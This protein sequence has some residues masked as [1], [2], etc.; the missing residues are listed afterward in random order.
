MWPKGFDFLPVFASARP[1]FVKQAGG[2]ITLHR[3]HFMRVNR[4][5]RIIVLIVTLIGALVLGIGLPL[6]V[7]LAMRK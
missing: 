7:W 6:I 5:M 1:A 3:P 4:T 2:S